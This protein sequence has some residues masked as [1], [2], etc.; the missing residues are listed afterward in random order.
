M[1]LEQ[2]REF[3]GRE[4]VNDKDGS[5]WDGLVAVL[6]STSNNKKSH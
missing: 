6:S 4:I 2:L 5:S 3:K 1:K